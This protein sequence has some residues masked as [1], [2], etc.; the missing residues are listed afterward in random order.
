MIEPLNTDDMAALLGIHQR[1]LQRHVKAGLP[2]LPLR[3]GAK[4]PYRYCSQ[5]VVRWIDENKWIIHMLPRDGL[6]RLQDLAGVPSAE[7]DI[8]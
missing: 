5:D 1:T 3:P 7:Q 8:A 2:I 6:L 4:G